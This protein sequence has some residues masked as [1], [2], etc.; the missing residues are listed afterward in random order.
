MEARLDANKVSGLTDVLKKIGPQDSPH[1]YSLNM[2]LA[3]YTE[4]V[5]MTE[6]SDS[7][8][9]SSTSTVILKVPR[10][11]HWNYLFLR[12]IQTMSGGT[13]ARTYSKF[14]GCA[15][16]GKIELRGQNRI[17][18]QLYSE[19]VEH[20]YFQ[21][22]EKYQYF[23]RNRDCMC[24]DGKPSSI[25]GDDEFVVPIP[26][27]YF[28]QVY[29]N[30]N[31]RVAEP[32]ELWIYPRASNLYLDASGDAVI[33]N[34]KYHALF[35][36]MTPE[37]NEQQRLIKDNQAVSGG[38]MKFQKNSYRET[39]ETFSSDGDVEARL[40][41]PYNVIRTLV[42]IKKTAEFDGSTAGKSGGHG[43]NL[44]TRLTLESSGVTIWSDDIHMMRLKN[45]QFAR[46]FGP[47]DGS[48]DYAGVHVIDWSLS[49]DDST[50][51][52]YVSFRNLT[53]PILKMAV[54]GTG[55]TSYKLKIIHEY[56]VTQQT[57]AESGHIQVLALQ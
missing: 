26:L 56:F 53:S 4:H 11:A 8:S 19:Q 33:G 24:V 20:S 47:F 50:Q 25:T 42:F 43:D 2:N 5:T 40:Y 3:S 21:Q 45:N 6:I 7:L 44:C 22:P 30:I 57:S 9:A 37:P 49:K 10:V 23:L 51:T 48:E 18:G 35:G 14:A 28:S 12:F 16:W 32:L 54:T 31:T 52:G 1:D 39:E 41:C 15:N 46:C 38:I 36:F 55:G 27:S 34:K 29:Q 13:T 17:L